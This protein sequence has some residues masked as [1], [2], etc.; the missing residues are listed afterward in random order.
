[1][2]LYAPAIC[3]DC[4]NVFRSD[5][6]IAEAP[7]IIPSYRSAGGVCPRCGGRGT[8]PPWVYRF[9]DVA[10]QCRDDAADRDKRSLA[11]GLAQFLRRHRT[12]RRTQAFVAALRGPWKALVQPLKAG[13]P[14]H[15]RAQLMFL[16]WTLT[17]TE[18]SAV[19]DA[20][21]SLD[22]PIL[23]PNGP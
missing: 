16:L 9:H 20:K 6:L 21:K 15:R 4:G 19:T 22:L 5:V 11:I 23:D 17:E 10:A 2:V 1:M 7:W 13:P 12:A 3:P 14:Q 8:I 18:T